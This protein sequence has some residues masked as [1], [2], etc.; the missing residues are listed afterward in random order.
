MD[1]VHEL[2][3]FHP[4]LA[5][6]LERNFDDVVSNPKHL[7]ICTRTWTKAPGCLRGSYVEKY[8]GNLKWCGR[9]CVFRLASALFFQINFACHEVIPRWID[10]L[11]F[12]FRQ[13]KRKFCP[14]AISLQSQQI[15][16]IMIA[17]SSA[18]LNS[19]LKMRRLL[20]KPRMI[21]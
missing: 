13:P 18:T 19:Q 17:S 8:K 20:E 14:W 15:S 4:T 12:C 6:N 11:Q 1:V 2:P 9:F 7:G 16:K 5:W 21:T 10:L 3:Q